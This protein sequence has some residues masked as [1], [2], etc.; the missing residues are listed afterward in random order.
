MPVDPYKRLCSPKLLRRAWHLARNDSRTDFMLDPYRFSEV[1]FGLDDLIHSISKGLTERNYHPKPLLTIDVPKSSLSVR[2]GSVL[3]I[4]DKIILFAVAQLIAPILD[5]KLPDS[6]YSWRVRKGS[7]CFDRV[8]DG[9]IKRA[10]VSA[11][12]QGERE[13]IEAVARG[14]T[15]SFDPKLHRLGRFCFGLMTDE[16]KA[17][18]QIESMFREFREENLIGRIFEIELM[19]RSNCLNVKAELL[20]RLRQVKKSIRRPLLQERMERILLAPDGGDKPHAAHRRRQN[21][22][23]ANQLPLPM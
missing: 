20:R 19:A 7:A 4:E 3:A 13:S 21:G 11:L 1:G 9:E 18:R 6:V 14:L 15:H 8:D 10:W 17:R 5:R 12:C 22:D 23:G 16:V 2:P